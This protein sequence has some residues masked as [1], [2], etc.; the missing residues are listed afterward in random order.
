MNKKMVPWVIS[1]V[2]V[3]V[4]IGGGL[5][6]S[7][8]KKA[9]AATNNFITGT[10]KMGNVKQTVSATGTVEAPTEYNLTFGTNGKVT[11]IDVK[12]GDTV[13]AGQVLAKVDQTQAQ[14]QVVQAQANLTQAQL[15]LSQL[16]APPTQ[17]SVLQ[18]QDAVTKAQAAASSA[19]SNLQTLQSYTNAAT[20]NAA[21]ASAQKDQ[22]QGS[23]GQGS[24]GQ[25]PG[26]STL[27]DYKNNPSDLTTAISQATNT[28]N[29]AQ[30]DLALANAQLAQ[31]NA[32]P[33]STDVQTAESQI[34]SAN[35]N[36]ASAQSNL[37]GT[38]LT[39][40]VDGTVTAVNGLIG[41]NSSG[42]GSGSSSGSSGFITLIPNTGTMQI[43]VPV[44]EADIA[45]VK[46]GQAADITL[47][48]YPNK[49][50][51]GTVTQVNPTGTTQS[52]VTTFGV[53]VTVP[54]TNNLMKVGMSA[55]VDIIVAEKDNVLTVPSMAVHDNGSTQ[56]VLIAPA[57]GKGHPVSEPVT[58][59][60]DDGNNAQVLQGLQ[61][62]DQVIIGFKAQATTQSSSN[63]GGFGGGGF[64][65]GFMY[66]GGGGNFK[67]GAG[68]GGSRG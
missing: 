64:G 20:L 62:G 59:G 11:E 45:N 3:V 58:I 32:G 36:L 15:K 42:G 49:N 66:R 8:V 29:N 52:G 10:V 41:A 50:F 56:T 34:T 31:V 60:I 63:R 38:V 67:G 23:Q 2:L 35:A 57:G 43:S 46:V 22:V 12:V 53:T 37:S 47:D 14:Q 40:P 28:Y 27:V 61:D 44:D 17:V 54:N 33:T 13:K 21:I 39:A 19:Q 9:S 68:G 7:K 51:S 5:W 55:N 65:G 48:A 30:A 4:L 26:Y 6:Y 18:A 16:Q 25:T 1:G 24:Q